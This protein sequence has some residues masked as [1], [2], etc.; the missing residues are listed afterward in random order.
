MSKSAT[1]VSGMG[2]AMGFI[3]SLMKLVMEAGGKE[4]D[5]H[6]LVTPG[7][8]DTLRKIAKIIVEDANPLDIAPAKRL[9][10]NGD[11]AYA[12]YHGKEYVGVLQDLS[13][14]GDVRAIGN[15]VP[16]DINVN[17]GYHCTFR[18]LYIGRAENIV[19]DE[20]RDM[21]YAPADPD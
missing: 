18:G 19:W 13:I 9:P 14:C 16:E 6:R 8:E 4:E 11:P 7:G 20:E 10:K 15:L 17:W 12:R 21:W 5:V 2:V 1:I 3:T